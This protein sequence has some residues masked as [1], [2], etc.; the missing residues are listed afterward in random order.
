MALYDTKI[1]FGEAGFFVELVQKRRKK[2][3]GNFSKDQKPIRRSVGS[4]RNYFLSALGRDMRRLWFVVTANRCAKGICTRKEKTMSKGKKLFLTVAGIVAAIVLVVVFTRLFGNEKGFHKKYEGTDLTVTA[5][6]FGRGDTY[7]LYL[8][9]HADKAR[10]QNGELVVDLAAYEASTA[11]DTKIE[12]NYE[13]E[14]N[15]LYQGEEGYTKWEINVPEAGMYRLYMEYYPVQ[16]RG[17]SIERSFYINEKLPFSGSDA[18]T[19]TRRWTDAS[20]VVTDNQGNDRR[21]TQKEIPDWCSDYFSD[22]MGYYTEPYEYYFKAGKNTIALE[23]VN[24]PVA[25]RK[26]ALMPVTDTISYK[27]YLAAQ[28]QASGG[29]NHKQVIQG[30][31]STVRS[32]S[33]LYA[34]SDHAS[35]NTVPYSV[36]AEKLN[37]GGGNQWKISGQWIEW[38]FTV[39]ED[40]F[41][42]IT[43][44]ARQ[45]YNRGMVSNRIVYI[46]GELP[47]KELSAVAFPYSTDWENVTLGDA[48][49]N[50]YKFYLT[51]GTHTIRMEATQGGMGAILSDLQDSVAR[52]N[53]IYRT[54]LVLTGASP[55]PNRDYDL[56]K[57]F[58]D[59][60][61]AMDLESKRLYKMLDDYIAYSGEMSGSVSTVQTLAR[62][63]EKFVKKP[64]KIS[65]EFAG[66]KGNI[67]GVGTSINNLS[68]TPLDIDYITVT[69]LNKK[70]DK[71]KNSFFAKVAHEVRSF[72]AS[73]T[74]DYDA[75][76]NAYDSE[77]ALDVWILLGRDQSNILKA[78]IDDTFT[79][80][81]GIPVNLKLVQQTMVMSAIVA[82]T[83]PDVLIAMPQSEPVNYAL[84][85]SVED[86]TQFEGWEELFAQYAKSS[87]EPYKFQGGIYGLPRVHNFNV[88]FYRKD[89]LEELGLAIPNTW[90]ELIDMIPTLQQNNLQVAIPSTERKFGTAVTATPDLSAFVALL[91]QN[92]GRMYNEEQTK[93]MIAEEAGVK[94]FEIYTR[95]YTHYSLEKAYDFANRFRSGEMPIGIQDYNTYNTLA[96]LA[97][98]IRGLWGMTLMPGTYDENVDAEDKINRSCSSW[99]DCTMILKQD[100][101]K[102]KQNAWE[103]LRWWGD[104]ETQTRF[105]SE[106]EAVLGTS[107]RYE[108]ANIKSFEEL[109]WSAEQR[110]VIRKMREWTVCVPEVAGG[111]FV[112]RHITNAARR[113]YNEMEDPRETLLDYVATINDEIKKKRDEFG[114]ETE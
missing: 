4:G 85:N 23:A 73:F 6:E 17:V 112:T 40:G 24:E 3:F 105:G 18:V 111:Y 66:F 103:F 113:V 48:K 55:D 88:M 83:G 82:G 59:A 35:P 10:P 5:N 28:P 108:T 43:I 76:G 37:Y 84:R 47:F 98:E 15:V 62:Q 69:G 99:G 91:Y 31:A 20:A 30:E 29:K 64:E 52:L 16:S 36:T 114:L 51:A 54:I 80:K 9:Q 96:V 12:S 104:S 49:G 21:P 87:Y 79:P 8:N 94:A 1:L 89:I 26:L 110:E 70:P 50:P 11:K 33:S 7:E 95:F 92:G 45:S 65:K 106:M 93:S 90:D 77:D 25:I 34:R 13:G 71:L 75:L 58:P 63:L 67:S 101:E 41:Y 102:T 56:D 44:K 2:V 81:T 107:A 78:M 61:K 39:P 57:V 22:Y 42:N 19:F 72:V 46:D 100:D 14:A 53:E 27:E 60:I 38:E 86:L 68:E 97:P 32:D 109:A 74:V